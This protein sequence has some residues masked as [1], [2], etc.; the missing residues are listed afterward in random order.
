MTLQEFLPKISK[1]ITKCYDCS[2]LVL[3][4]RYFPNVVDEARN[5]INY[6]E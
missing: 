1:P 5:C 3:R 2:S 4:N 6:D